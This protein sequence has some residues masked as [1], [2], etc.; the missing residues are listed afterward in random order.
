M[1]SGRNGG[2]EEREQYF[3]GLIYVSSRA[4]IH[5]R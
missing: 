1:R 3:E 5:V 4:L 2:R